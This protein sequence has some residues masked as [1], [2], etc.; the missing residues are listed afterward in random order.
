VHEEAM[1]AAYWSP[2]EGGNCT[3]CHNEQT[4]ADVTFDHAETDWPLTGAHAEVDCRACHFPSTAL[5]DQIF[6][7]LSPSC[8]TC[9]EDQHGGQFAGSD[10]TTD[11]RSCHSTESDWRA[12]GFD[13]NTTNFQLEGRHAEIAC[14]ECHTPGAET[15]IYAIPSY[16]CIDCHGQ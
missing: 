10:G 2:A 7:D 1:T 6:A 13:H 16:E 5:A 11:C 4:W 3:D 12:D 8:T 9:H 14:A 15:L